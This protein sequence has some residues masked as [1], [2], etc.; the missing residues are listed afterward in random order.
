MELFI[1]ILIV[2]RIYS[3]TYPKGR[4]RSQKVGRSG[5]ERTHV[6]QIIYADCIALFFQVFALWK[7]GICHLAHIYWSWSAFCYNDASC[8]QHKQKD[9]QIISRS[10]WF[11]RWAKPNPRF[12]AARD[13][14]VP[15]N[16]KKRN[17]RVYSIWRYITRY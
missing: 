14:D 15:N 8:R 3:L 12:K 5:V 4:E 10:S 2:Y 1:Y 16:I 17:Y 11:W 13:I 6:H 9:V 7:A